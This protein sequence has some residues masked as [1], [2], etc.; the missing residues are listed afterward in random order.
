MIWLDDDSLSTEGSHAELFGS[1]A[2]EAD[3]FPDLRDVCLLGSIKGILELFEHHVGLRELL[4]V[5]DSLEEDLS[6][7]VELVVEATVTTLLN[8]SL[9]WIANELLKLG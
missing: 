7:K 6:G 2:C 4:V 1:D 8:I 9:V 3:S 5:A